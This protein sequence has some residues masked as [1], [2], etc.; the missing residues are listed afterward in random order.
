VTSLTHSTD[1]QGVQHLVIDPAQGSFKGQVAARTFELH[2]H[3]SGKPGSIS[4]NGKSAGP[5]SWDSAQ[6]T[7]TVTLPRHSIRNRIE[8]T[9]R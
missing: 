9:W 1:A 2:I 7:A 8:V 6:A 5:I 3:M 4:L